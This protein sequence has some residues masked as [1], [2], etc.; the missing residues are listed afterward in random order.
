MAAEPKIE[1]AWK[2]TPTL[3]NI[4]ERTRK[5][6]HLWVAKQRYTC[7]NFVV[8]PR[9]LHGE[10][11]TLCATFE[12]DPFSLSPGHLN[13]MHRAGHCVD[14]IRGVINHDGQLIIVQASERE[15]MAVMLSTTTVDRFRR[16]VFI[17]VPDQYL[18][19][20]DDPA[21]VKLSAFAQAAADHAAAWYREMTK[22]PV[23]GR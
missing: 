18:I 5:Y 8:T 11:M 22:E 19:P 23:R 10:I 20:N 14:L 9:L 17:K 3:H 7:E 6:V 2:T 1:K 4:D 12:H 13:M 16:A 15:G 21:V